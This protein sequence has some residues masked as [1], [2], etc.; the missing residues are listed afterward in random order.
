MTVH[1]TAWKMTSD[2]SPEY[3]YRRPLR[4]SRPW[5]LSW[6]PDRLLLREEAL[7]G[8]ELD[9]FLSDPDLVHDSI[10]HAAIADRA[11][12]LDIGWQDALLL[13]T[14]RMVARLRAAEVA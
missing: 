4:S 2:L 11:D 3:A 7:A 10:A 8:M 5:C 14:E 13:L 6:L 9:E 12:V 1:A